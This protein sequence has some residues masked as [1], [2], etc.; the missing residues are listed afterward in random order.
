MIDIISWNVN[1]IRACEKKGLFSFL[2]AE[3]PDL[4]CIQETKAQ[5]DQLADHFFKPEG[6]TSHFSD[7]VRKGYS[8]TAV[9][10]KEKTIGAPL[11]VLPLGIAEFDDEG[12]VLILEYPRFSLVNAY[13]PNSQSEGAR[14]DYKLRFC[15]AMKEKLDDL[16]GAGKNVILCG[17]Y[18]IAHKPIDLANPKRNEKNPGYL[19]E[20][21]DWME[22]FTGNGYTDTFR[23]FNQE[24]GHYTW[25]SYRFNAREKNIGWR[26][27]YFCVNDGYAPEV[28]ESVILKD[29]M[30]SDHCPLRL[31]VKGSIR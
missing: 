24:P 15:L 27:D 18:N 2:E 30:G 19:P 3:S 26:I 13:F 17:D 31:K 11:S 20:E 14:L 25:W 16:V 21:R 12:R 28:E 4:F 23:M 7:A 10:V 22:I 5:K 1:G 9:Y 8:G 29:T 6:Y